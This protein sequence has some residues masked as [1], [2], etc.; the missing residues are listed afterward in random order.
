MAAGVT[1]KLWEMSDMVKVFRGLGMHQPIISLGFTILPRNG[2]YSIALAVAVGLAYGAYMA[3]ADSFVF[4]NII[5]PSQ[6]ALIANYSALGRIAYF[7]LPVIYEEITFRLIL[8]T[9]I[10]W[11]LVSLAGLRVWCFWA[12]IFLVALAAY[13]ALHITYL[14]TL[15]PSTLVVLREILLHGAAGTLWGYLYWRHGLLAAM[16]GHL[17]AHLSLEPL[18]SVL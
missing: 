3:L 11:I 1:A 12:A 5:P 9:A 13:P 8:L 15:Q 17:S 16:V 6:T 18:L 7:L 10:A 2:V 14:E 4:H